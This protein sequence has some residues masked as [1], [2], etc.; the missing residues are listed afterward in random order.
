M[1]RTVIKSADLSDEDIAL[2]KAAVWM[3]LEEGANPYAPNTLNF[4]MWNAGAYDAVCSDKSVNKDYCINSL[5][6]ANDAYAQGFKYI[7][8]R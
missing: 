2:I 8:N 5:Y 6:K 3:D 7:E 4:H 1:N